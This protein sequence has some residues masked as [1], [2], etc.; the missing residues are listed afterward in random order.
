MLTAYYLHRLPA[1]YDIGI[2]RARARQ[3]GPSWD[4]TP[5]LIFKGFLLREAGKHGATESNYASFYLWQ[6]AEGFRDFLL[7][8]KYRTVTDSF[9]RAAI[10][11]QAAL[12]ARQGAAQAARFARL[13]DIDV[14]PDEDLDAVLAR[15]V[16]RNREA[17]ARPGVVAAAVSV[18]PARWRITRAV[19]SE[20]EPVAGDGGMTWQVLHLARPMLSTLPLA[21]Q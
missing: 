7:S 5:G 20:T 1:D 15:E 3:R 14:E 21:G 17:A 16:A 9:G 4:D 11:T 10:Q 12:D 18:D 8:G 2:I 6:G 13:Q 19:L